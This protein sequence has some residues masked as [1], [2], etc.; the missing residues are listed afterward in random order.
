MRSSQ[1][2]IKYP[3]RTFWKIFRKLSAHKDPCQVFSDFCEIGAIVFAISMHRDALRGKRLACL[4]G[5]YTNAEQD[6]I[7]ELN[8]CLVAGL[9]WETD[10][11]GEMFVDLGLAEDDPDR[12]PHPD[13]A[14][15]G[16]DYSR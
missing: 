7:R 6:A 4:L 15:A 5:S 2:S 1:H 13:D 16:E 3:K 9:S 12:I 11:L 10:F 14:S 8:K